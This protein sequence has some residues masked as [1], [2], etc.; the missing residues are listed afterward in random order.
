MIVSK[1]NLNNTMG[2]SKKKYKTQK[3]INWL[4]GIKVQI[5]ILGTNICIK[6]LISFNN[7]ERNLPLKGKMSRVW[8]LALEREASKVSN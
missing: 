1:M 6:L 5:E 3:M 2:R 4:E 8:V 7:P